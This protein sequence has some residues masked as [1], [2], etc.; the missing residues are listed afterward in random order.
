MEL[1]Q[2]VWLDL[3]TPAKL[4]LNTLLLKMRQAFSFTWSSLVTC[5]VYGVLLSIVSCHTNSLAWSPKNFVFKK[6]NIKIRKPISDE[7]RRFSRFFALKKEM[8]QILWQ[9]FADVSIICDIY[10]WCEELSS[11]QW[12][13]DDSKKVAFLVCMF[14]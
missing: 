6:L 12:W 7:K 11:N 4:V 2:L 14:A 3:I 8:I 5:I 1:F 9:R 10:M 13:V